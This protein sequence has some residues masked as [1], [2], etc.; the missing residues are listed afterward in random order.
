MR[1]F[2]IRVPEGWLAMES[3][4]GLFAANGPTWDFDTSLELAVWPYPKV[5]ELL[6]R[7]GP[8][9]LGDGW[10]RTRA[11]A[12]QPPLQLAA[13]LAAEPAQ[14]PPQLRSRLHSRLH[15]C[16]QHSLPS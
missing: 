15:S 9:L 14:L 8:A 2:S 11:A 3:P 12:C 4:R 1:G 5:S 16:L 10:L 6:R 13:Q 7:Y